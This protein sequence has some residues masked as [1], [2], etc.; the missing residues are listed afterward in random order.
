MKQAL[1]WLWMIGAIA[2][3]IV[4]QTFRRSEPLASMD[5]LLN[6][7]R[8]LVP[9]GIAITIV[10][11]GLLLGALIHGL[12]FDAQRVQPGDVSGS[13]SGPAPS[14]GWRIGY[15]KG[16]LL[17][18]ASFE[19]ESGISELKRGWRSGEWL[20]DHTLFRATLVIVGLPLVLIGA[21]GTIAL[22]TDVTAVRLMLLLVVAY[23]TVRLGYTLIRA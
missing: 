1:G 6:S 10:G 19:E 4:V 5:A 18:G 9:A 16:N 20:S 14:G 7:G 21:F 11:A 12:V 3:L 2:A 15:F 22:I 23:A 17:W 8:V 13:Y